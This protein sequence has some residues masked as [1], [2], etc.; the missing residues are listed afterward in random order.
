MKKKNRK[1][2][3]LA[4]ASARD[5]ALARVYMAASDA[6]REAAWKAL[7][8][9]SKR[10]AEFTTD[11]VWR[12]L[13]AWGTDAP[14]EPRA[15]GPVMMLA[16]RVNICVATGQYLKSERVACHRRPLA[17]YRSYAFEGSR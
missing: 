12:V 5:I 11:D 9:V 1:F 13:D 15:M 16:T 10:K 3:I 8:R 2:D 17:V 4:S 7:R 6:W 14:R